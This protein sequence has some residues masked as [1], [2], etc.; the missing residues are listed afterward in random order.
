MGE[1]K[2]KKR[3]EKKE[4]DGKEKRRIKKEG[5]DKLERKA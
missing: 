2:D 5:G 4:V 1:K 3:W